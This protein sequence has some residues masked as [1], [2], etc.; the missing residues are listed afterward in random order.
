M[1]HQKMQTLSVNLV[2]LYI[3][4]MVNFRCQANVVF[5]LFRFG[6]H[7][8]YARHDLLDVTGYSPLLEQEHSVFPWVPFFLWCN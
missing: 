3:N 2:I 7:N 6:D 8:C 1:N 4:F 5:S